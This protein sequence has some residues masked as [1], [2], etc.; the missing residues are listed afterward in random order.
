MVLEVERQVAF[1]STKVAIS[2]TT[3]VAVN[4]FFLWWGPACRQWNEQKLDWTALQ[5]QVAQKTGMCA[6]QRSL[7]KL[8]FFLY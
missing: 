2:Q 3:V 6:D 7:L 4:P 5:Q 8:S 1:N